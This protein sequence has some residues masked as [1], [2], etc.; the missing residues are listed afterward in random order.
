MY[1]TFCKCKRYCK[2]T[3]TINQEIIVYAIL[4]SA[5]GS[6]V[7]MQGLYLQAGQMQSLPS[8]ILHCGAGVFNPD[9]LLEL[10]NP[11]EQAVPQSILNELQRMNSGQLYFVKVSK[12]SYCTESFQLLIE[13]M[14]KVQKYIQPIKTIS[15]RKPGCP[16]HKHIPF[17]PS[18]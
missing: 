16:P 11:V 17:Q 8:K 15:W 10:N 14:V 7:N 6:L 12:Q 2:C 18:E 9:C 4:H 3:G 1:F 5:D 13:E